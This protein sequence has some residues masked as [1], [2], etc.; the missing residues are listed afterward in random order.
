M[1]PTLIL[2]ISPKFICLLKEAVAYR[3]NA[4]QQLIDNPNKSEEA[5]EEI[6]YANDQMVLDMVAHELNNPNNQVEAAFY[7]LNRNQ[8]N[9]ELKLQAF[10]K[11]IADDEQ[12]SLVFSAKSWEEAEQINNQF[13]GFEPYKPMPENIVATQTHYFQDKQGIIHE[14]TVTIYQPQQFG[15]TWQCDYELSGYGEERYKTIRSLDSFEV[16]ERAIANLKEELK[17]FALD[18]PSLRRV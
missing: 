17:Q 15:N 10:G 3:I 8:E 13:L 12:L 14:I 6:D 1:N 5:L 18:C 11:P 9:T 16:T 4:M 2:N 7:Q